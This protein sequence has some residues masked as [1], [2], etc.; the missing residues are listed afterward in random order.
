[1]NPC[2]DSGG[3]TLRILVELASNLSLFLCWLL[4]TGGGVMSLL[5]GLNESLSMLRL[6]CNALTIVNS[7]GRS[8]L[9]NR[10]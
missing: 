7:V 6:G 2:W 4:K 8:D 3:W 10:E 5:F 9:L 1:M